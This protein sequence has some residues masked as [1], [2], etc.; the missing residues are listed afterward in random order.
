MCLVF[1]G[2]NRCSDSCYNARD[3]RKVSYFNFISCVI[4]N[5]AFYYPLVLCFSRRNKFVSRH[6]TQNPHNNNEETV[7][8]AERRLGESSSDSDEFA[9]TT[10][11]VAKL[12]EP[13]KKEARKYQPDTTIRL[14]IS[15]VRLFPSRNIFSN[16]NRRMTLLI[17]YPNL[18]AYLYFRQ[19]AKLMTVLGG[20]HVRNTPAP[21]RRPDQR[22]IRQNSS[23]ETFR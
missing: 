7:K 20:D 14:T 5:A 6:W 19:R 12:A 15:N 8:M 1:S 9:P 4:I 22:R 16:T 11:K 2:F 18:T 3:A 21:A 23:G 10:S 13:L 17:F